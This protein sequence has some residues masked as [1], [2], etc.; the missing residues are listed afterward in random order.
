MMIVLWILLRVVLILTTAFMAAYLIRCCAGSQSLRLLMGAIHKKFH[1]YGLRA[2][3]RPY[4][5]ERYKWVTAGDDAVCEDCLQRASWAPMD[6][7][8]WM[9]EGLPRTP[10]ARTECGENC[11]CRL[12]LARR[13]IPSGKKS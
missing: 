5:V 4:P 9:K 8:D 7:A 12:V 10:E 2:G 1:A 13:H 11:R 6:I 3:P